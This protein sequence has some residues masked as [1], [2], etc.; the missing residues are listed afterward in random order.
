MRKLTFIARQEQLTENL[1]AISGIKEWSL[2]S[3]N[4]RPPINNQSQVTTQQ[5]I[6]VH[7]NIL[8]QDTSQQ[9]DKLVNIKYAHSATKVVTNKAY[10]FIGKSVT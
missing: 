1:T 10:S 4:D 8:R 6:T 3:A 7:F 5:P 9:P 2:G